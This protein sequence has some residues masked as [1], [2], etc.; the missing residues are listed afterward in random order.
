[1]GTATASWNSELSGMP[2]TSSPVFARGA[3]Y[4]DGSR[5]GLFSFNRT[6]SSGSSSYRFCPV[7]LVSLGL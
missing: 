4:S 5:A 2:T 3:G 7:L 1:M 6:A